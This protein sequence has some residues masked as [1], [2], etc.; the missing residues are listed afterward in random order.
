MPIKAAEIK[1]LRQE[2]GAG[3]MDCQ[4]A[5]QESDGD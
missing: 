2:T 4:K 1:K 5:L 3:V